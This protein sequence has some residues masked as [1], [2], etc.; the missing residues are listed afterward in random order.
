MKKFL[1]ALK[2]LRERGVGFFWIY[3]VESVWFDLRHGTRTFARV[4]KDEQTITDSG[5][6]ADEGLLYVASFTSVTRDTAKLAQDI[7]GSERFADAQFVDL[8]CGKGKA[9]MVF[10]LKFG[11][12]QRNPAVGIEYD[13]SLADLARR[14]IE[15]CRGLGQRIDVYSDSALN[16]RDYIQAKTLIVY[17]YNSFQGE[18]LREVLRILGDYPHVLIYV[19]P[20]ERDLL[21]DFGYSIHIENTGRYNADTWLV[22]HSGLDEQ[23]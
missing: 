23:V 6:A 4:P 14:N 9:L 10:S 3:F 17:L 2:V 22:A 8:G 11:A 12:M 13:R 21:N 7:L 1:F 5:N 20:A 18:T 16:L 19:D 15:Q